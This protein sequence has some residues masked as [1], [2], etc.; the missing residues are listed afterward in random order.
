MDLLYNKQIHDSIRDESSLPQPGPQEQDDIYPVHESMNILLCWFSFQHPLQS[1]A[2]LRPF[3][4]SQ[5]SRCNTPGPCP[6]SWAH[7]HNNAD[8]KKSPQRDK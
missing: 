4:L 7:L 5:Q 3:G 6:L 1:P 2:L 8:P